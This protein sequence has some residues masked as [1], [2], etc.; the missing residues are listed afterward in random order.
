VPEPPD[1]G[2]FEP[3]IDER[4]RGLSRRMCS[5]RLYEC[6][7]TNE[8]L[9]P[10]GVPPGATV[11]TNDSACDP[12]PD[13]RSKLISGEECFTKPMDWHYFLRLRSQ[14]LGLARP[15]NTAFSQ[16]GSAGA[17]IFFRDLALRG[18]REN[19]LLEKYDR[20]IV[21]RSDFRWLLPHP[22][23]HLLDP[24]KIWIPDGMG[25]N[26]G[27]T[28][29][30]AVMSRGN[31]EKYLDIL[32]TIILKSRTRFQA[33]VA[34]NE[35]K[36]NLERTIKFHL[37]K[38]G[39]EVKGLPYVM[40]SVREEGGSTS[41]SHGRWE[42]ELNLYVKYPAER[43]WARQW[44]QLY[45]LTNQS[46]KFWDRVVDSQHE[47]EGY[48]TRLHEKEVLAW[49]FGDLRRLWF[50][51]SRHSSSDGFCWRRRLRPDA[52]GIPTPLF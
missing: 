33:M 13:F 41:F 35:P 20:F 31:I 45:N 8:T 3:L 22:G 17:L 29:R 21:T 26:N 50:T 51:A 27:Y 5:E 47:F 24:E 40:F 19:G 2:S 34:M 38:H 46:S 48:P 7:I 32:E 6:L 23:L 36:W 9:L 39:V 37:A 28:D 1:G 14:W 30:H 15:R 12:G 42:P 11:L 4:W 16:R 10:S 49:S 43:T 44:Q 25:F 52:L 18:I